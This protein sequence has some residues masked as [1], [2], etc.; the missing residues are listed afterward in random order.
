MEVEHLKEFL[1]FAE[2][3]NYST[4]AK[5]LHVAQPTLSQ[6]ISRLSTEVGHPLVSRKG[7]AHLTAAGNIFM[8]YAQSIVSDYDKMMATFSEMHEQLMNVVRIV[9]VRASLNIAPSIR[10]AESSNPNLGLRVEFEDDKALFDKGEFQILDEGLVDISFTTAPSSL[11]EDFPREALDT[12]A[13]VALPPLKVLI[14]LAANHPLARKGTLRTSDLSG[15]RA[16]TVTTPFWLNSERNLLETL[17]RN[18]ASLES[19]S[20]FVRTKW[21]APMYD[22]NFVSMAFADSVR[23]NPVA[24]GD[25]LAVMDVAD[26]DFSVRLYGVYR[27]D[28]P[29]PSV[30]KFVEL[31]QEAL[32]ASAQELV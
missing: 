28:N 2:S 31:W 25:D 32:S 23:L 16:I 9:D 4:A 18:G 30:P 13:F 14:V 22:H 27:K 8:L 10:A 29:N 20:G 21:E 17:R 6:H 15:L 11:T 3:L 5:E 1:K 7:S 19:T 26:M 12:Y 24:F